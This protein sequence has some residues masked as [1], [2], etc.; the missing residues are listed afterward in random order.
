MGEVCACL[1]NPSGSLSVLVLVALQ[2]CRPDA[3]FLHVQNW[4]VERNSSGALFQLK[5]GEDSDTD[6]GS[7]WAIEILDEVDVSGKRIVALR[8]ARCGGYLHVRKSAP[9][10]QTEKGGIAKWSVFM[11]HKESRNV[12]SKWVAEDLGGGRCRLQSVYTKEYLHVRE[13]FAGLEAQGSTEKVLQLSDSA[14]SPGSVWSMQAAHPK[15]LDSSVG[16]RI[17]QHSYEIQFQG[18]DASASGGRC[19]M[20]IQRNS[21]DWMQLEVETNTDV[22]IL[23][24]CARRAKSNCLMKPPLRVVFDPLT[25]CISGSNT[26]VL[27]LSQ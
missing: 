19:T 11:L 7:N 25:G 12:G 3:G 27:K 24:A 5:R 9:Q 22:G 23:S 18:C 20:S 2:S 6:K 8:S 4:S 10:L 16:S 21:V 14:G 1:L 17:L 15:I 13:S 26:R